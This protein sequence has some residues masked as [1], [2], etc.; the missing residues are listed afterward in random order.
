MTDEQIA[1]KAVAKWLLAK[2]AHAKAVG[3]VSRLGRE[4]GE[5]F[6]E[7]MFAMANVDRDVEQAV[8][9]LKLAAKDSR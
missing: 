3:E 2:A 9:A 5:R 7:M 8:D 6:S 1:Q 4:M